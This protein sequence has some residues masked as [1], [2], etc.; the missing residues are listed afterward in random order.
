MK[1]NYKACLSHVLK[2]EGGWSDHPK[3]P[4]G[5]TMKGITLHTYSSFLSRPATKQ[6]LRNIPEAHVQ[7]I[8]RKNYWD[9]IRG[10][11]LPS[12]LDLVTFDAAVNSGPGRGARWTQEAVGTVADGKV[13]PNTLMAIRRTNVER[14]INDACDERMGFLK[15]L[16]T[17]AT[18]GNGWTRRVDD[19]RAAALEMVAVPVKAPSSGLGAIIAAIIKA[20][21]A[22]FGRTK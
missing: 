13:G 10:D 16:S 2:W 17:W 21:A 1:Q 8:Y 15:R 18:F 19:T 11:D 22:F 4:G 20:L 14:A 3:D 6:E 9:A 7:A 12:G 5:A